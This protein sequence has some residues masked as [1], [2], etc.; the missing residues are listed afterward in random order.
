MTIGHSR[1]T[2]A[3]LR[4]TV[5][6]EGSHVLRRSSALACFRVT[7]LAAI[8]QSAIKSTWVS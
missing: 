5:V 7:N 6:S 1:L 3:V 8:N 4:W 2:K